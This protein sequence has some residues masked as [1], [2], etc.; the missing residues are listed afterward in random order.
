MRIVQRKN[1]KKKYILGTII[2][3]KLKFMQV[4]CLVRVIQT[5]NDKVSQVLIIFVALYVSMD[6]QVVDVVLMHLHHANVFL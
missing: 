2:I 4:F 1:K 3:E 6:Q 5:Y